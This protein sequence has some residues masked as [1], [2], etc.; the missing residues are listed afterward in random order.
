MHFGITVLPSLTDCWAKQQAVTLVPLSIV[1]CMN[2]VPHQR[3]N[4]DPYTVCAVTAF[5]APGTTDCIA[6][7]HLSLHGQCPKPLQQP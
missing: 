5:V 6:Y 1:P 7:Q 3:N 4:L 2:H